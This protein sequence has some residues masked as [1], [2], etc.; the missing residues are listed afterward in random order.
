MRSF[1]FG[2]P[3]KLFYWPVADGPDEGE[4]YPTLRDALHAAGEGDVGCAWIVT[5]DGDLISPRMIAAL[6]EE[7]LHVPRR[8]QPRARLF[9]WARAA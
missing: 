4:V 1:E 7:G 3:A 2:A 6:R 5:H 9:G 8:K